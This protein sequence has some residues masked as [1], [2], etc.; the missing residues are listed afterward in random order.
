MTKGDDSIE[1]KKGI[2]EF[3]INKCYWY[4][5]VKD[6]IDVNEFPQDDINEKDINIKAYLGSF[7]REYPK[8]Y[9]FA[10]HNMFKK[11]TINIQKKRICRD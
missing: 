9:S 5:T 7:K 6:G 8:F 1:W 4:A 11:D 10:N 3:D 2:P